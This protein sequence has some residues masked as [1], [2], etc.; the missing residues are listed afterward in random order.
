MPYSSSWEPP[1]RPRNWPGSWPSNRPRW[2]P[3]AES[4]RHAGD[5][6]LLDALTGQ[7]TQARTALNAYDELDALC[8]EQ[9]QA[10]DA[11]QQA[12]ALAAKRR[13]QLDALDAS[14]A[15][16]DTALAVLVDAPTRQLA[17]QNQ[18]AHLEARSTA[19]D[20]LALPR[21]RCPAG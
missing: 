16:A 2:T 20:A 1:G 9:K 19:L 8:R 4:A 6:A 3:P 15:A 7:V 10:Q 17:L 5:A 18:A 12:G 13:T 11:A 21:R 14:L